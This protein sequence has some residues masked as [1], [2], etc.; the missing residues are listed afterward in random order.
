MKDLERNNIIFGAAYYPEYM[1]FERLQEDIAMM[2]EAGMNTVRIAQSTWSTL[3]PVEGKFDFSYVDKVLAAVEKAGMYTVIGT[4]TYA[5][6]S[7]LEKKCPEVM[8]FNG[9]TRAKYGRRQIMDIVHPVFRQCAENVIC[10]LLEHTAKNPCVIGFQ[11][12]NETKHYGTASPEVQAMFVEYLKE[13]FHTT[14]RLNDV[15]GL[16]YWSNS[17]HDWSDFPDMAGCIHGGLASE[18]A[19][20]QRSLAAE[21]LMWQSEIVKKYKRQDQF[22]THNF[23]FEWKKFGADIAQDGYSYGVQ[24]DINHYE[25][26]KAVTIAGTDIYH[27]TQDDLTGAEIAFGGNVYRF[28][29]REPLQHKEWITLAKLELKNGV[30]SILEMAE[31]DSTPIEKWNIKT[32]Q[33]VPV[34]VISYSPN[35]FDEQDGIG[36]RHLFFFL[37]DCVN[38][39]SPNGYYNEF[40]KSDLEKHKRVFEA[41]GAKC[42]VEDTDDQ[43]SGIGF[44]MTKRADLVVKVKGATE[45]VMKIKF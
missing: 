18:F 41:L 13:Q 12:D 8:V 36:H 38:N 5:I 2:Q 31:N 10:R 40:L 23:D 9:Y 11:I 16:R 43:L 29:R 33:F 27:P 39:E 4:P 25:A 1:P 45:R 3:E 42:H 44:S 37:K 34:S 24:P 30:F 17:I 35:Y 19:K 28:V 21:Y 32:N 22:I 15:F 26:S 14:E 6:P 7:W 20:F